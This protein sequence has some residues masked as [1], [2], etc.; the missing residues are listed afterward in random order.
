MPSCLINKSE[1]IELS[2]KNL[3]D[4]VERN[5]RYDE[6]DIDYGV[7]KMAL[8]SKKPSEP[9]SGPGPDSLLSVSSFSLVSSQET[10]A[11]NPKNPQ[12]ECLRPLSDGRSRLFLLHDIRGPDGREFAAEKAK[13]SLPKTKSD[14]LKSWLG[15]SRSVLSSTKS[16]LSLAGKTGERPSSLSLFGKLST[17]FYK[18]SNKIEESSHLFTYPKP[19]GT[20]YPPTGVKRTQIKTHP[21]S[22]SRA[23]VCV[24]PLSSPISRTSS[25][26]SE[27]MWKRYVI[28]QANTKS[29]R[30][31]ILFELYDNEFTLYKN[32]CNL[33]YLFG[34]CQDKLVVG[35]I[36]AI[37][38]SEYDLKDM[39]MNIHDIL[40]VGET[41]VIY[42]I[43]SL[44]SYK[45][46]DDHNNDT[47]PLVTSELVAIFP[48]LEP[49]Y[50]E[51]IRALKKADTVAARCLA[52][53][54]EFV[55]LVREHLGT[56]NENV[57]CDILKGPINH[58]YRYSCFFERLQEA[59][60]DSCRDLPSIKEL[61]STVK[62]VGRKINDSCPDFYARRSSMRP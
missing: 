35:G 3:T 50:L 33:K 48:K 27:E 17:V 38:F 11:Q 58:F 14:G 32:M 39:A 5:S 55:D 8:E 61:L 13:A 51:Y 52:N 28:Y 7:Q 22:P 31:N 44:F 46:S 29:K 4:D 19:I 42:A 59:T 62:D 16:I 54:Q 18:K 12:N 36:S 47:F 41:I 56:D 43:K 2:T 21:L 23:S 57:L 45:D 10:A 24:S 37:Q 6:D 9:S 49:V 34:D 40:G 60:P 15:K 20:E 1:A 26:P 53:C 25:V 30:Y